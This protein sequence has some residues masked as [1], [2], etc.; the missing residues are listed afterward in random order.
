[1]SLLVADERRPG[2]RS[3]CQTTYSLYCALETAT[4]EVTGSFAHRGAAMQEARFV[5]DD[6]LARKNTYHHRLM[7]YNND[8]QTTFADVRR[9][10]DLLQGRIEG[11][12]EEVEASPGPLP[13]LQGA[14]SPRPTL[15]W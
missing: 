2:D 5:I 3:P 6:D 13:N 7:D 1:M 10:F 15:K 9:F 12:L 11:R 8:R 4:Y 14:R